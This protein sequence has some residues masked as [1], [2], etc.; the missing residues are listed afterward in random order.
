MYALNVK[1]SVC[2][3]C[4]GYDEGKK[5]FSLLNNLLSQNKAIQ[6]DMKDV[7]FTSSSFYNAAI[8]ELVLKFDIEFLKQH[9]L[10]TNLS[11]RDKFLLS[12]SIALAKKVKTETSIINNK[13]YPIHT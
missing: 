2:D 5:L 11:H 8:G 7:L 3:K 10:F 9:L 6:I 4:I 13:S 12:K 1:E